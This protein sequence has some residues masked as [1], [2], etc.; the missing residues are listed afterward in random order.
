MA[1]P[2]SYAIGTGSLYRRVKRPGR[3]VYHPP[4]SSDEVNE[5]VELNLCSPYGPSWPVL[6]WPLPLPLPYSVTERA[7]KVEISRT[8][9]NTYVHVCLSLLTCWMQCST[10]HLKVLPA[11]LLT[12]SSVRCDTISSAE[13]LPTFRRDVMSLSSGSNLPKRTLVLLDPKDEVKSLRETSRT[14]FSAT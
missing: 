9:Q 5:K 1:H 3:G 7:T 12:A 13:R 14:I 6:G 10:A 2:A 11:V 8:I 4:P